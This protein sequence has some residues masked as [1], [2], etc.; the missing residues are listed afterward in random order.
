MRSYIVFGL[1]VNLFNQ[2]HTAESISDW[3]GESKKYQYNF[4][5]INQN[6]LNAK[7]EYND[8]ITD[9]VNASK[10]AFKKFKKDLKKGEAKFSE[11]NLLEIKTIYRC[12]IKHSDVPTMFIFQLTEALYDKGQLIKGK[13]L[14][15]IDE[16]I[17]EINISEYENIEQFSVNEN[18][19]LLRNLCANAREYITSEQGMSWESDIQYKMAI[20]VED[21]KTYTRYLRF[22]VTRDKYKQNTFIVADTN[23]YI[24][25][26]I[27]PIF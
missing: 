13:E 1:F 22:C 18:T 23:S 15:E 4:G 24:K 12:F 3:G 26:I 16:E 2:L 14:D 25:S 17:E 9:M 27:I 21:T 19:T 5:Q 7:Q 20:V 11:Q 8:S 10:R 6:T